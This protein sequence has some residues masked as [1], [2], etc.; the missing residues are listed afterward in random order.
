MGVALAQKAVVF[1]PDYRREQTGMSFFRRMKFK[2]VV[3]HFMRWNLR[4]I[5][6]ASLSI[7]GA[8]LY[9]CMPRDTCCLLA[10]PMTPQYSG[11]GWSHS[12]NLHF[13]KKP[14]SGLI[15]FFAIFE[16]ASYFD[17]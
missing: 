15:A 2:H 9:H 12:L 3:G 11:S 16:R 5:F 1:D 7:G 17:K 13:L 6:G 4:Q 8:T 14:F 10:I